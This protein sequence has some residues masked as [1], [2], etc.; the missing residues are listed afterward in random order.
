MPQF[1][2]FIEEAH[3]G[4][5]KLYEECGLAY[6]LDGNAS[7]RQAT[8]GPGGAGGIVAARS[9]EGIGYFA[10]RQVWRPLGQRGRRGCWVGWLGGE[11]PDP[12]DLATPHALTG[13]HVRMWDDRD[14][15]VPTAVQFA[16]GSHHCAI[17]SALDIDEHGE[18]RR[19]AVKP[20]YRQLWEVAQ[21]F[22]DVL[23]SEQ[24]IPLREFV[25]SAVT[26]LA[27]NYR[28]QLAEVCALGLL[29]DRGDVAR[30]VLQAAIDWP[31]FVD[32]TTEQAKKKDSAP[33][34]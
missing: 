30:R 8:Q 9:S 22:W 16:D 6:A 17:P 3:A 18:L 11:L 14:W 1:L 32:W 27:T 2:Y 19:G 13:H 15:L 24:E 21:R 4:H 25:D 29:D 31:T 26:V 23:M 5:A 10:D 7:Y 33:A 28:V 20:C 34:A 12:A